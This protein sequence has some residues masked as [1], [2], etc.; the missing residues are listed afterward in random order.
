MSVPAPPD[1]GHCSASASGAGPSSAGAS[2]QALHTGCRELSEASGPPSPVSES[3]AACDSHEDS[4][5]YRGHDHQGRGHASN[6]ISSEGSPS[7]EASSSVQPRPEPGSSQAC[8]QAE[9]PAAAIPKA[10]LAARA[11]KV[12]DTKA[13]W[14]TE[15]REPLLAP[16][17]TN[18]VVQ[19]AIEVCEELC[20]RDGPALSLAFGNFDRRVALGWLLADAAGLPLLDRPAAHALGIKVQRAAGNAKAAI[21]DA[22]RRAIAPARAAD[23]DVSKA[24]DAA[25]TAVLRSDAKVIAAQQPAAV[26]AVPAAAQS[27]SGSRKRAR[28]AEQ[29]HE[30]KVAQAESRLRTAEKFVSRLET[31]MEKAEAAY[32]ASFERLQRAAALS[33]EHPRKPYAEF[34]RVH[35]AYLAADEKCTEAE[36]SESKAESDWLRARLAERDAEIDLLMLQYEQ[37]NQS[38]ERTAE[39]AREAVKIAKSS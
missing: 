31:L 14:P 34:K 19:D 23:A 10:A 18:Q 26:P 29:W 36:L 16:L 39:I 35:K 25:E 15:V 24:Q 17:V 6:S 38:L 12:F 27:S 1:D 33:K 28:E 11:S 21:R 32:D 20:D 3:S 2:P 9:A 30:Q 13:N 4:E 7:A 8:E 37:S 22:R 5:D